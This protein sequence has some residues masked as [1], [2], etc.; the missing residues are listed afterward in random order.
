MQEV[1]KVGDSEGMAAC[2]V[3]VQRT[4]PRC[5]GVARMATLI[6]NAV[7]PSVGSSGLGR[8]GRHVCLIKFVE[9]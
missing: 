6:L 1:G 3:G 2:H 4:A 7:N 9:R 8:G 5:G